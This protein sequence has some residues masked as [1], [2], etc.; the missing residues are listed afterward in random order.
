MRQDSA[1]GRARDWTSARMRQLAGRLGALRASDLVPPELDPAD[2]AGSIRELV[3]AGLP[4]AAAEAAALRR[5]QP[6]AAAAELVD[7]L[8]GPFVAR[9]MSLHV[10]EAALD[11]VPLAALAEGST[12]RHTT[13]TLLGRQIELLSSGLL[14]FDADL[15]PERVAALVVELLDEVYDLPTLAADLQRP[16]LWEDL[17]RSG[18]REAAKGLAKLALRSVAGWLLA[19]QAVLELWVRYSR[20]GDLRNALKERFRR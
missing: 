3:R 2:L 7:R 17:R 13:R 14:I 20:F 6:S 8:F 10:G 4:A 12:R 11:V 15:P 19:S 1:A 9:A 18:S 16:G 5:A